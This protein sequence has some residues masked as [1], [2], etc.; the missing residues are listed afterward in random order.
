MYRLPLTPTT[1]EAIKIPM[2]RRGL[3]HAKFKLLNLETKIA[4]MPLVMVQRQMGHGS[5]AICLPKCRQSCVNPAG[6]RVGIWIGHKKCTISSCKL[7]I[8]YI[9]Q[10]RSCDIMPG[11]SITSVPGTAAGE[12]V[13]A[14][15]KVVNR[16]DWIAG[17]KETYR[18]DET[19][20][21]VKRMFNLFRDTFGRLF[22]KGFRVPF[23]T[24]SCHQ[25]QY[26][27]VWHLCEGKGAN[28][29]ATRKSAKNGSTAPTGCQA[30]VCD[31]CIEDHYSTVGISPEELKRVCPV[32][33]GICICRMHLRQRTDRAFR[34]IV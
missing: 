9:A 11:T 30:F 15:I 4:V 13:C 6:G 17:Q 19:I 23:I 16:E 22:I 3:G 18:D 14:G 5:A 24:K 7:R 21:D 20:A 25:C 12:C 1:R 2:P 10:V 28:V 29:H 31:S 27:G 8:V 33:R 34:Y 32:C 26:Q